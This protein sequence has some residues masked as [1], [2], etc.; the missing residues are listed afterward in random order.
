MV[1]GKISSDGDWQSTT[2]E[3]KISFNMPWAD[4]NPSGDKEECLALGTAS[5]SGFHDIPC[6]DFEQTFICMST[7][8]L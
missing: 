6:D 1:A 8:V 4:G 5:D 7:R 2:T 3:Q